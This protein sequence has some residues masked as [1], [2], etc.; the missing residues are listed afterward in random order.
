MA[1]V[2]KGRVDPIL[3][4][5]LRGARRRFEVSAR[6]LAD[7]IPVGPVEM[8]RSWQGGHQMRIDDLTRGGGVASTSGL[9]PALASAP[10][11][12]N[13][14]PAPDLF[15]AYGEATLQ[16]GE[17]AE[18]RRAEVCLDMG[19]GKASAPILRRQSGNAAL[20]H[21]VVDAFSRAIADRPVP[22]DVRSGIAC[23]EVRISAFRMPPVPIAACGFDSQGVNCFWPFKKIASVS[24][25]LLSVDYTRGDPAAANHSLIRR[26]R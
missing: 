2:E 4:D 9:D 25:R 16:A 8:L 15:A 11:S 7:S 22:P 6:Q 3:Y 13:Q 12:R 14:Q 24:G 20:D 18:E 19:P 5:Y 17:G 1:N 26:P 21:L 23:Y 10:F